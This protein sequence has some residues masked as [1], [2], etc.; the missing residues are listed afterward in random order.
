MTNFV[1]GTSTIGDN[2]IPIN[3]L[4]DSKQ[5]ESSLFKESSSPFMEEINTTDTSEI[6]ED[7]TS[8]VFGKVS[9]LKL[10]LKENSELAEKS[11]DGIFGLGISES[12]GNVLLDTL[13]ENGT[14]KDRFI[15]FETNKGKTNLF[16]RHE[17]DVPDTKQKFCKMASRKD[18]SQ[19]YKEGWICSFTHMFIANDT[20]VGMVLFRDTEEVN[21]RVIF[22]ISNRY[23][24]IPLSY[25]STIL[26]QLK[27]EDYAVLLSDGQ[28]E[29]Y[30]SFN[31]NFTQ[32]V[33]EEMPNIY[34]ILDGYAYVIKS[35]DLFQA[36]GNNTV[37]Y[38]KFKKEKKNIWNLGFPFISKH[39]L[40]FDYDDQSVGIYGSKMIDFKEEWDQWKKDSE[41]ILKK[42]YNDRN[43]I[44]IGFV[45]GMA[46]IVLVLFFIFR[47][48]FRKNDQLHSE[49]IEDKGN[50]EF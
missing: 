6:Y 48:M 16:L 47:N 50:N 37:S 7:M 36:N 17:S 31:E 4:F 44:I 11:F 29:S 27:L 35:K 21:A 33:L 14:I 32:E 38:L 24:T 2:F 23:L 25:A 41:D 10:N 40:S 19:E 39:K 45:A 8:D 3:M 43:L 9:N 34:F 42:V 30:L 46:I 26:G 18:L 22:D 12:N 49:L 5:S 13:R 20:H 15:T 28:N 1:T